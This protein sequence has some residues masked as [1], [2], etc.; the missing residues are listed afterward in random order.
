MH[1]TTEKMETVHGAL[2]QIAG[3]AQQD[4]IDINKMWDKYGINERKWISLDGFK[5]GVS[6][7]LRL[8]SDSNEF[9]MLIEFLKVDGAKV[10]LGLFYS[11]LT[12]ALERTTNSQLQ[13]KGDFFKIPG[14]E[15]PGDKA[16]VPRY[17][18]GEESKIDKTRETVKNHYM[19]IHDKNLGKIVTYFDPK[20]TGKVL[21]LNFANH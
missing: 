18:F 9:K 19:L 3:F 7:E 14:V 20:N 15:D 10:D 2:R 6:N 5:S 11:E 12:R 21:K 17:N 8:G 4:G 1:A 13:A 16:P